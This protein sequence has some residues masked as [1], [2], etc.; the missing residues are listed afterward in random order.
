MVDMSCSF[1]WQVL[2]AD[3][4]WQSIPARQNNRI[5]NCSFIAQEL[6]TDNHYVENNGCSGYPFQYKIR[7]T[8]L[9]VK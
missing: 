5:I 1:P 7:R 2:A 4:A 3:N 6:A 9:E 8:D